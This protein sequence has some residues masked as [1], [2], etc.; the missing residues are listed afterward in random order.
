MSTTTD[1]SVSTYRIYKGD[2][3]RF[4]NLVVGYDFKN[5]GV[6]KNLKVSKLHLYGRATNLFTKTFD[7]RLPFDP[8]VGFSGFDSQDM[9]QYRTYTVGVNIGL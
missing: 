8:E 9:L 6:F 3:I 5:L 1:N 2:H 7:D 4:R